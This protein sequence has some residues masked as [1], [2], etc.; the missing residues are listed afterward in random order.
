MFYCFQRVICID[1]ELTINIDPGKDDCFYHAAKN[2]DVIDVEYQVLDGGH[3]DLDI[4]FHLVDPTGRILVADYKKSEN[5]HRVDVKLD[6][7]FKFCFDNTFSS[8]NV[9]TVFFELIIEGDDDSK[10]GSEEI[11]FNGNTAN[12][13]EVLEIAIQDVQERINSVRTHFNKIRHYQDLIRSSETRD[14]NII[15][16][17]SFFVTTFSFMQ[18]IVMLIVGFTQVLM[19]KSLFDDS[20][21]VHQVWKKFIKR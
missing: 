20:S 12:D 19:I 2:G 8:F 21:K 13:L 4:T 17:L 6:G 15:E 7:D 10:W 3:G 9:K 1:R 5:S 16:E 18:L 11:N 14:K